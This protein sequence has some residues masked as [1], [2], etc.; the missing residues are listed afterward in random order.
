MGGKKKGKK[1]KKK[2]KAKGLT[3]D[4]PVE[5]K[6]HILEAEIDALQQKLIM[7]QQSSQAAKAREQEKALRQLQLKE[8][9]ETQKARTDAII[10]DMTRQY[11]STDE[12]LREHQAQLEQRKDQNEEELEALKKRK[13]EIEAEKQS[14]K[15]K[16]DEE[17]KELENYIE[18]MHQSF[19][20]MLKKTL[21]KM[22]ERIPI[23]M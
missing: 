21:E 15:D 17:I 13:Q 12:E 2:G 7:T 16:K 6:N 20:Q 1:G 18:T 19:S 11:K 14:I 5:E 8:A 3:D 23:S 9:Q 22:K 4:A 10:A